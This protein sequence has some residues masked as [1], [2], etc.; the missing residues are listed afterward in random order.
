MTSRRARSTIS[1]ALLTGLCGS[2]LATVPAVAGAAPV[3][4]AVPATAGEPV[5]LPESA[6]KRVVLTAGETGPKSKIDGPSLKGPVSGRSSLTTR[7]NISVIYDA[8]FSAESQAAFQSAVDTIA[9]LIV[10]TQ[11]IVIDAKFESLGATSTISRRYWASPLRTPPC[12]RTAAKGCD[13]LDDCGVIVRARGDVGLRR[14]GDGRWI[15]RSASSGGGA[16]GA[17]G[18]GASSGGASTPAGSYRGAGGC[19]GGEVCVAGAG[20][21][22]GDV[23]SSSDSKKAQRAWTSSSPPSATA[24]SATGREQ[25]H[26]RQQEDAQR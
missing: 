11:P 26:V 20:D 14:R 19:M 9:T 18:P 24:D 21:R 7:A 17:G 15:D 16:S 10:A 23:G 2:L 25:R 12:R 5:L 22:G 13:L 6:S 1:I 4:T 8:G 3:V